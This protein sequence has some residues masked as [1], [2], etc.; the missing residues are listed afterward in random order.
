MGSRA[1]AKR[2]LL[3]TGLV[4]LG[5]WLLMAGLSRRA[6]LGE[7]NYQANLIRLQAFYF[8]S[9]PKTVL[10]GSSIS[11]RMLPSYF[12]GT[13]LQPFSNLGIDGT[14][15]GF[16]LELV[17]SRPPALVIVEANMLC[18][19]GGSNEIMLRETIRGLM[20]Q[21][22]GQIPPLRAECRPSSMLYSWLKLR[23][24]PPATA[25]PQNDSALASD[26]AL[27]PVQPPAELEAVKRE[28]RGALYAVRGKGSK[29]VIVRLPTGR[30]TAL[31]SAGL[32]FGSELARE[33]E[34]P[35]IDLES[36]CI[37]RG[38]RTTYTDGIHMTPASA[39]Q[40]SRV[41]A[42]LLE[43]RMASIKSNP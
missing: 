26:V 15:P 13:S 36:E 40:T 1:Q 27:F 14:G 38:L 16:G 25:T 7:T 37:R 3:I 32:L 24:E 11:G 35:E 31:H 4:L 29:L 43:Q 9:Q 42:E 22:S 5:Y 18:K 10:V 23:R 21:V 17:L 8:G 19:Q 30:R 6:Q 20:F 34:I 12:Q 41:L 2:I 33:L 39:R 28:V